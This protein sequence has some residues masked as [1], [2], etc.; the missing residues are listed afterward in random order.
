MTVGSAEAALAAI[1]SSP[2]DVLISDVGMA[3]RDGYDL[4]RDVRRMPSD[5]GR[6]PAIAL[7]AFARES[8]RQA[9]LAAGYDR[10]VAKPVEVERLLAAVADVIGVR[11][12]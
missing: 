1:G 9:A 5:R 2:L 3:G 12:R 6:I 8:D 4:I 7:S 10:H 11:S